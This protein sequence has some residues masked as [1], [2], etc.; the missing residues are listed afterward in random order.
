MTTS[1]ASSG[2]TLL[3]V[4]GPKPG[5]NLGER[6]WLWRTERHLTRHDVAVWLGVT[7]H[8]VYLWE[9]RGMRFRHEQTVRHALNHWDCQHRKEPI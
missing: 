6:L 7:E 2:C 4:N 1:F 8:A 3:S 5:G 9:R